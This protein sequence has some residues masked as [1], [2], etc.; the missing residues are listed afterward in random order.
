MIKKPLNY[1][2]AGVDLEQYSDIID[3]IHEIT[4]TTRRPGILPNKGGFGAL[5]ELPQSSRM[6]NP[7]L[8]SGADGVGTKLKLANLLNQHD[9]VGIDLVAMCVNDI[10]C[11]GAEPLFFLDYYASG[12]LNRVQTKKILQGISRGCQ[13]AGMALAGGETAE[14]PGMYQQ[15]DYDLAGFC[16]GIVDKSKIIDGSK[17]Q[18]GNQLI[19]LASSGLHSNGFSLV[20]HILNTH[21]IDLSQKFSDN[22]ETL[23]QTLLTP[24]RIY[25]RVIQALLKF[26][27]IQTIAHITGGGIVDNLPRVLPKFTK[28]VIHTDS[29]Q[30]PP[31]FQWLQKE[32]QISVKD[33]YR[34]F[35]VGVGMIIGVSANS[36]H[37]ALDIIQAAGEKAW[38]I[39]EV[40]AHTESSP[41][42]QFHPPT[43]E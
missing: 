38:V 29:W 2:D 23:G 8:V 32:G 22:G 28:A 9:E 12:Q 26:L 31:I 35:N 40:A 36:V 16:V 41:S 18:V 11:H 25:V 7:V 21:Q 6:K 4:A 15:G 33:M 5:F 14:M 43:H 37:T 19:A 30:W 1:Q 34:T 17:V 10:I 3:D 27:D 39:G 24:T 42:V 20:R 13:I